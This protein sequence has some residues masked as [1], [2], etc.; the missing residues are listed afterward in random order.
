MILSVRKVNSPYIPLRT[1]ETL[2]Y[3]HRSGLH[4]VID[5][6]TRCWED[7]HGRIWR[8]PSFVYMHNHSANK[9]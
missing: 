7:A 9:F 4:Y 2:K 6:G 8:V 3:L 5:G 1:I